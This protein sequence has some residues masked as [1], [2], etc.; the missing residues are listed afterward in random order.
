MCFDTNRIPG[1]KIGT[2]GN[3]DWT[4]KKFFTLIEPFLTIR[5]TLD[6]I[7]YVQH[8]FKTYTFLSGNYC[9]FHLQIGLH[10]KKV[11]VLL[12]IIGFSQDTSTVLNL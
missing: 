6:L 9:M 4:T 1:Y 7:F 11:Q 5:S 10:D 8:T 2:N 3:S 12:F